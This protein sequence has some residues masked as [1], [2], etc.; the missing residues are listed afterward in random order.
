MFLEEE[1]LLSAQDVEEFNQFIPI[2][3]E[4][5]GQ[6]FFVNKIKNFVAGKTTKVEL[7]RI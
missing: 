1:I 6:Y 5:Y 2:Y 3:I 4:K 7:I